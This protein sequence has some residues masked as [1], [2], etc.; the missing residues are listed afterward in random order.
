[1]NPYPLLEWIGASGGAVTGGS[2]ARYCEVL[3]TGG[4]TPYVG[5]SGWPTPASPGARPD[6]YTG[7]NGP[8]K[9]AASAERKIVHAGSTA[10][11]QQGELA[12]KHSSRGAQGGAGPKTHP[13]PSSPEL[14]KPSAPRDE[15]PHQVPDAES[16]PGAPISTPDNDL[17]ENQKVKKDE[18]DDP[19]EKPE[20][21]EPE[22]SPQPPDGQETSPDDDQY[23]PEPGAGSDPE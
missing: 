7:S 8:S 11:A 23:A 22:K 21:A 9:A 2:E 5:G 14:P 20:I 1:M 4:P 10:P 16:Q 6:L 18:E 13:E 15:P 19:G 3:Q 12:P 17:N